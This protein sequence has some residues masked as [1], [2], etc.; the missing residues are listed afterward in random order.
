MY[1]SALPLAVCLWL[2]FNPMVQGEW[3]LFAWLTVFAVL[4]R[5]AMT[6]YHVPHLALGAELTDDFDERTSIVAFRMVFGVSGWIIVAVG[7]GAFFAATEAYPNGQLNPAN[8]PPFIALLS[9]GIFISIIVTCWGTRSIVAYLPRQ[10]GADGG[11]LTQIFK[12][13]LASFGNRSFRF[14]VIAFITASVPVGIGGAFGL[15]VNT[16]YWELTPSQVPVVLLAQMLA[17]LVGYVLAPAV[18][19]RF[20]KKPV[21]IWGVATWAIATLAPFLLRFMGMF[22][23]PGSAAALVGLIVFALIAGAGIAQLVVA[24][25]SMMADIADEHELVS[26]RRNEGVF[27][28][29][30]AF[31][32]KAAGGAGVAVG[33]VLLDLIA[34]PTG[35]GIKTA[36]DIPAETLTHLAILAGPLVASAFIPFYWFIQHYNID[37]ERHAEIRNALRG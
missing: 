9:V 30:F 25:S 21:L 16:F 34:W 20:D 2:L 15:Y 23:A 10:K 32:N 28:G 6:L 29:A 12:D 17:T 35:E 13:L 26:G 31:C 7:F 22:P 11:Q 4:T 19:R 33:G 14:L 5:G 36:A 37:R 3:A 18:G 27:F 8:Y 24:I 1:A